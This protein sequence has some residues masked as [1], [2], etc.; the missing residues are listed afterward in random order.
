MEFLADEKLKVPILAELRTAGHDVLSIC[1]VGG[2]PSDDQLIELADMEQRILLTNDKGFGEKLFLRQ[3]RVPGI[4]V[5]R[6]KDDEAFLKARVLSKVV[7][8]FGSQLA[9]TFPWSPRRGS[10]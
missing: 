10:E 3:Q 6:F 7:Q 4:V 2:S 1:D 8:Q 5:L 9:G